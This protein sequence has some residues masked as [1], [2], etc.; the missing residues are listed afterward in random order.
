MA[1]ESVT[2]ERTLARRSN[3][4]AAW[5]LA[6]GGVLFVIA[7]S[8]HPNEDR[9]E[10]SMAQQVRVMYEDPAWYPA[11][12]AMFA[13]MVLI[14]LGLAALVRD[15]RVA[16]ISFTGSKGVGLDIIKASVFSP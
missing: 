11:H 12:A 7:G 8:V 15:P 3:P 1:T 10:L 16:I 9:P 4:F 2:Q 14:T 6:A 5:T 13:G